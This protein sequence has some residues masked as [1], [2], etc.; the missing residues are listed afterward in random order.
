MPDGHY[1]FI[2]LPMSLKNS[3]A[4]FQRT[5]NMVLQEVLGYGL[6]FILTGDHGFCRSVTVGCLQGFAYRTIFPQMILDR[7]STKKSPLSEIFCF[8][9]VE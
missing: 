6:L 8:I 1:E 9:M 4:I 7:A 5:M 2:R 3:P